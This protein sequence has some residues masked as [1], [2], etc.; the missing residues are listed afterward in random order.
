VAEKKTISITE[1]KRLA[2]L[3]Q[4]I[5]QDTAVVPRGAFILTAQHHVVTNST[6]QG[7]NHS[8]VDRLHNYCHFREPEKLLKKYLL[9]REGLSQSLDFMDTVDED[10]P[11]GY[12]NGLICANPL[13]RL[14]VIDKGQ[15]IQY[16]NN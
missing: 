16:R 7:L 11:N 12:F 1:E 6:F 10:I 8:E 4:Q 2:R 15:S 3:I 5:D 13:Y 9:Q 14:L